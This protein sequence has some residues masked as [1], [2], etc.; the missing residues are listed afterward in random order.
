MHVDANLAHIDY[1]KCTQ[2]GKCASKCPVKV[3]LP[4]AGSAVVQAEAKEV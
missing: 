1:A 2:C 4:P 3:I